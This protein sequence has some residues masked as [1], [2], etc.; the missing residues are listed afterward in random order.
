[1]IISEE[2]GLLNI[3]ENLRRLMSAR[4]MTQTQ[5]SI[6]AGVSQPFVH[7]ILEG[8]SNPNAIALRNIAEVLGTTSDDLI[9]NPSEKIS[10]KTA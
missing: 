7:R 5:L 4:N 8:L 9:E 1:M 2:R 3:A 6:A 10:K